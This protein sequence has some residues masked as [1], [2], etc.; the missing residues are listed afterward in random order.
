MCHQ[1]L[2]RDPLPCAI[3]FYVENINIGSIWQFCPNKH[4]LA[5]LLQDF[6]FLSVF[7]HINGHAFNL[8]SHTYF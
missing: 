4:V 1:P 8:A 3:D 6:L 5:A 7:H 2:K